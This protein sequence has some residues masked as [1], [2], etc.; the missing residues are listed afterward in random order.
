[1]SKNQFSTTTYINLQD[2]F[3]LEANGRVGTWSEIGYTGPGSNRSGFSKSNVFEY[4]EGTGATKQWTVKNTQKLNDCQI[5]TTDAW[6]ISVTAGAADGDGVTHMTFTT[7]GSCT[8]L[9]P[10]FESMVSSRN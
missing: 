4:S 9:T 2:A 10:S 1:V 3:G 5:N 7:G 8:G 6:Y